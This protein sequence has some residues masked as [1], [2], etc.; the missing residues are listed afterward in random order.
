MANLLQS[1]VGNGFVQLS[2][3][4]REQVGIDQSGS[5]FFDGLA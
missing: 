4:A 2:V 1:A 3:G 5:H